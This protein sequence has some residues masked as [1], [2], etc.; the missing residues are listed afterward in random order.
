MTT[1]HDPADGPLAG[2]RV[3]E[4]GSLIAGPLC[5]RFLADFG[6]DVIKIEPPGVGD[7]LRHWGMESLD[8][9]DMLWT[10]YA[11]NKR[12][13]T[14]DLRQERGRD[15]ARDLIATSDI[16]VENFRPGTMERWGLGPADL[17]KVSPDLIMV[18]VSGFGQSGPYSQ[19]AGFGS[20]AEAMGGIRYVTGYPD[21]PPTRTGVSLGDSLAALF[22][23]MG[24]LAAREGRRS[25]PA[26]SA[27]P[28]DT[29]EVVDVA[30]YEAVYALMESLM[31][32]YR[33]LGKVRERTGP[34]LP[35][36][37]PSN[38]YPCS[39][40]VEVVIAANADNVFKRLCAVMEQP[41]LSGDPDFATH[42]ARGENQER[43]DAIVAEWTIQHESKQVVAMLDE[44]GVPAGG[45]YTAREIGDDPHFAA[46]QMILPML[47]EA[48]LEF[49]M[50]GVVPAI[51]ERPGK[52]RWA[53][54]R[55]LGS[56]NADVYEGILGLSSDD[57]ATLARDGII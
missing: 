16:V 6:A 46:R 30:V 2:M 36:V 1:N 45:I 10:I 55:E 8:G 26:A 52:V 35:H 29:V 31:P 42:T 17:A 4:M 3:V 15:I 47:L 39:D 54:A 50:P 49:P 20:I 7:P 21:R 9:R 53:G 28:R 23:A 37:A 56:H 40:G 12:C 14:L 13:V 11:R 43:I 34:V 32:D 18:R 19:K 27:E 25:R 41:E 24:A 33:L 48:G 51:H 38:T 44:A 57:V 22:G 5:A